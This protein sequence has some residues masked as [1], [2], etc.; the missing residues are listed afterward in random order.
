MNKEINSA[1]V[2][3]FQLFD[4]FNKYKLIIL[5]S[6]VIPLILSISYFFYQNKEYEYLCK[7]NIKNQLNY[8]SKEYLLLQSV[9]S[10]YSILKTI[11]IPRDLLIKL[12]EY[13]N[14]SSVLSKDNY[15]N[16]L[17]DSI[18]PEFLKK[19]ENEIPNLSIQ[20]LKIDHSDGNS[21]TLNY[22]FKEV[23]NPYN[24]IQDIN[25][26]LHKITLEKLKTAFDLV[27]QQF[28]KI[29]TFGNLNSNEDLNQ[30]LDTNEALF[31]DIHNII[32]NL[33]IFD[34]EKN[35][36]IDETKTSI[37]EIEIIK[38]KPIFIL[39]MPL[40][41][42]MLVIIILFILKTIEG[43]KLYKSGTK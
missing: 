19:V 21:I 37:I 38:F 43:Y 22:K 24:V 34:K 39:L 7:L 15:L 8:N 31:K 33:K 27:N 3:I 14:P 42:T 16:S 30:F 2:N 18:S 20:Y 12:T 11:N 32:N 5:T 6:F 10:N 40:F 4:F 28:R 1:E 13:V 25:L 9:N 29:T 17:S 36:Y 23:K 41:V 26:L 35:F